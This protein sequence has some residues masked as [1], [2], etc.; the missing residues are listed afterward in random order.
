[1]NAPLSGWKGTPADMVGI[2]VLFAP[3]DMSLQICLG[4]ATQRA[5]AI[6]S[7]GL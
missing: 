1:M 4:H 2:Q 7:P 3:F 6:I 5:L